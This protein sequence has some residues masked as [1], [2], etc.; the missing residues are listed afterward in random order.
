MPSTVIFRTRNCINIT[1]ISCFHSQLVCK[2]V[3][4]NILRLKLAKMDSIII[5]LDLATITKA[6]NELDEA[7]GFPLVVIGFFYNLAW[8]GI[9]DTRS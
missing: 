2:S 5:Y 8:Q 7:C 6:R 3:S 1:V 9:P 4:R